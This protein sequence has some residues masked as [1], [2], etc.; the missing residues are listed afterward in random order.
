MW[1]N[2]PVTTTADEAIA[3]ANHEGHSAMNDAKELL[4]EE[5]AGQARSVQAIKKEATAA[6]LSWR[7]VLRAKT[8]LDIRSFKQGLDEGWFWEL[9]KDATKDATL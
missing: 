7:T 6:G 3:A 5:L 8:E 2:M 9:P 1:D 4:R